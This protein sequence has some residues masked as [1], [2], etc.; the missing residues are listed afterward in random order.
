M[1][2]AI[3]VSL[4]FE[5][6]PALLVS[7]LQRP[8]WAWMARHCEQNP[9]EPVPYTAF[10]E[11][12]ALEF[13]LV[14]HAFHLLALKGGVLLIPQVSQ[15]IFSIVLK[16]VPGSFFMLIFLTMKLYSAKT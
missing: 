11:Q 1:D 9:G 5:Q 7:W 12:G 13:S 10:L 4:Q 8:L 3:M 15:G 6:Y 2:D 16:K 14:F